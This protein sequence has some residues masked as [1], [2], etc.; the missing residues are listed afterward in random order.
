MVA[1]VRLEVCAWL[2]RHDEERREE[3]LTEQLETNQLAHGCCR[4]AS[5]SSSSVG[6]G[7]RGCGRLARGRN[8]ASDASDAL[9]GCNQIYA[10]APRLNGQTSTR[11][12]PTATAACRE[13]HEHAAPCCPE[14][15]APTLPA[16]VYSDN[17]LTCASHCTAGPRLPQYMHR[18][19]YQEIDGCSIIRDNSTFSTKRHC[20][21]HSLSSD[22]AAVLLVRVVPN[23]V[24]R[25]GNEPIQTHVGRID[26]ALAGEEEHVVQEAS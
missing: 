21:S 6:G 2:A 19:T 14:R 3:T 8:S 20:L 26:R 23:S 12:R 9:L 1:L 15:G 10:T 18:F 25:A 4:Q 17:D 22:K 11:P 13:V 16:V 7:V 24:P 5:S